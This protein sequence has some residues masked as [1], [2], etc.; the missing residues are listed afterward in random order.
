MNPIHQFLD[1]SLTYEIEPTLN[2][3][4][5]LF[6]QHQYTQLNDDIWQIQNPTQIEF[7]Q[8][9]NVRFF[10]NTPKQND[11]SIVTVYVRL[12]KMSSTY[13]RQVY[14]VLNFLGDI[15]GLQSILFIAAFWL[16]SSLTTQLYYRELV[17]EVV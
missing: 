6:V 14:A 8:V 13:S 3:K 16:V 10:S 2:Q 4:A 1:D 7:P 17:K 9:Q 11:T 5:D 15:G 12:D